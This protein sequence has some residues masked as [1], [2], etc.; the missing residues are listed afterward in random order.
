MLKQLLFC[1]LYVLFLF[2][3]ILS[4][5]QTSIT[6]KN[7]RAGFKIIHTIDSSRIYKTGSLTTDYLHYRP[8]D[9]DIWYPAQTSASDSP[10]Q[11]NDFL[12]LLEKRAN[13]YTASTAGDGLTGK[14]VKSFA[15]GFSC[16]DSARILQFK[17][18]SYENVPPAKGTFPLIVYMAS[19]NSMA[20]ENTRLFEDLAQKGYVVLSISSIGRYPGDMTMKKEDLMEQVQDAAFAIQHVAKENNVNTAKV[21]IVGY[22]W[23]GLAGALLASG[24]KNAACL[25]SLD[26][27]EFHHYSAEKQ[28]N[29]D[30]DD[31]VISP[32]F[33][34]MHLS[35]PYL[36][37]E[38][39]PVSNSRKD[40]VYNFAKKLPKNRQVFI[41]NAATHQDFSYLPVLVN[42]S[43]GCKDKEIYK[44]IIALTVGFL[45]DNVGNNKLFPRVLQSELDRTIKRK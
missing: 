31:L 12:S 23:G 24:L 45:D 41:V 21:G 38:S 34:A 16:S 36:R 33:Q 15:E 10:L 30:F 37:L 8:L 6:S 17:T 39:A 4:F 20:Y 22:S 29:E 19:Y 43:G 7:F 13:Y 26:G 32:A 2:P 9:L 40:S 42:A 18:A 11:F 25:V 27:S 5:G 35:V 28:E 3:S 1:A 44:R 14:V